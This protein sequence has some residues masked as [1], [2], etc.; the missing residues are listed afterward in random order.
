MDKN[1]FPA[2]NAMVRKTPVFNWHDS[3]RTDHK[4]TPN[5]GIV[6]NFILQ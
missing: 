3:D 4:I 5:H 6:F 2:C 1:P